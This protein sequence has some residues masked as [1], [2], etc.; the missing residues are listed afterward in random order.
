[1]AENAL[2]RT[3]QKIPKPISPRMHA[4]LDV[5]TAGGFF[6]AAAIFGAR[7]NGRAAGAAIA[8]GAFVTG[9]SLFTDYNG[10]GTKPI[11]F[12]MHGVLDVVQ[13]GLAATLPLVMDFADEPAAKFF[14]G[15][16]ANE[17][18]V[19][20]MTDFEAGRRPVRLKAA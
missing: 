9:F 1:M 6:A 12:P 11:S 2:T 10:E 18:M 20:S 7:G 17:G 15:Q 5:A 8:N 4:W 16:A 3:F 19:L 13:A 14:F